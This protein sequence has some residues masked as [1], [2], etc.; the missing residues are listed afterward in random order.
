MPVR[1]MTEREILAC[2]VGLVIG[3]IWGLLCAIL[4]YVTLS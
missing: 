3:F 2:W 4:G 1:S